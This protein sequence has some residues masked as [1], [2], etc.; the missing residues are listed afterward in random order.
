MPKFDFSE[1][2]VLLKDDSPIGTSVLKPRAIDLDSVLEYDIINST[3]ATLFDVNPLTG[4]I[5]VN[6]ELDRDMASFIYT[7]VV[8][9]QDGGDPILSDT[10]TVTIILTDVNDNSPMFEQTSYSFTIMENKLVDTEVG[11]VHA[12]DSDSQNVTYLISNSTEDGKYYSIDSVTGIIVSTI[13]FDREVQEMYSFIVL[14]V[15]DPVN[16]SATE[17]SVNVTIL[18]V[19]D[20]KPVFTNDTYIVYWPEDTPIDTELSTVEALDPD[21]DTNSISVYS[22]A[23][24]EVS[25]FFYI[26]AS[27]GEIYLSQ[28]LDRENDE[29]LVITVIAT[30][31]LNEQLK[32]MLILVN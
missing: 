23:F 2:K 24:S 6:G 9:V 21:R 32:S 4:L 3:N 19:N 17:V 31:A 15:D 30:D 7:I 12:T 5:T 14:A 29:E 11:Q 22:I 16:G 28:T 8:V 25:D 26:N 27:S 10:T 20:N 13:T 1:Y 18:D